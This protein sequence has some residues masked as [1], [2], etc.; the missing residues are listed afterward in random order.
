MP[1]S[2]AFAG[3]LASL[4]LATTAPTST[5]LF[6]LQDPALEESSGL[7]VSALHDGIVWTHP[8]GGE[9][10][11][12]MA[13]DGRG[14]TVATVQLRG[15][16]PYDPEALAPGRDDA[17]R[18]ALFLGDIGDNR[19]RRT[20]ISVFRFPEPGRLDDQ[21]VDADWFQFSYPD[22]P[23]DAEALLVDPRDGRIWVATKDVFGGGL[24]RAPARPRTGRINPLERVG[25]V[26][27]LIT[28]GAFLPDGGFMLRSYTTAFR[29]D[30][31]RRPSGQS[32]LPEQE[33]G[34]SLAVDGERL[35]VGSEGER[36]AVFAVPLPSVD[37]LATSPSAAPT[38]SAPDAA[39]GSPTESPPGSG[40]SWPVV[41]L[42]LLAGA[43]AA[44]AGASALRSRR[45]DRPSR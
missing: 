32:V 15:L 36:S 16:D 38:G 26:P 11:E 43:A 10:A 44:A 14:R 33:Q 18:P 5:E 39:P 40:V 7:A 3:A 6:R 12:V 22:G 8:D 4:V 1:A 30:E 41:G 27:G 9:V 19:A 20:D 2:A 31:V 28:D 37:P 35:L 42:S 29:Y 23:R 21:T 17:G 13:I 24:Y 45:R 25:D 34:E